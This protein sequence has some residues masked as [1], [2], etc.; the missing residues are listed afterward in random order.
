[1]NQT[2]QLNLR[3]QERIL[4]PRQ[5]QIQEE[6]KLGCHFQNSKKGRG[7][8]N[9]KKMLRQVSGLPLIYVKKENRDEGQD[10]DHFTHSG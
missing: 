7:H 4:K 5:L 3:S 2:L 1:M 10:G 9:S 8:K 6:N